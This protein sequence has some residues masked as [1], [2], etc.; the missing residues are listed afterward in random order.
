MDQALVT[1]LS[2]SANHALVTLVQDAI[3]STALV[4]VGEAGRRTVD[5]KRW[6]RATIAADVVA[7]GAGI[8]IQRALRARNREPLRA[9]RARTGG[10]MLAVTGTAG[11]CVG[12]LQ[13]AFPGNGSRWRQ[14][15][16]VVGPAGAGLAA[17]NTWQVR[18]RAQL[19]RG[20]PREGSQASLA[21]SIAYGVGM[22]A[23]LS[24]FG[25]GERQ[26][27]DRISS[28]VARVLPGNA[29][30]WRPVA[31]RGRVRGTHGRRP[32]SCCEGAGED[33]ARP[34]SPPKRRST[35]RRRTRW[36][37]EASRVSFRSTRFRERAGGSCGWR[38]PP[39]RSAK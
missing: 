12:A 3:Q 16:A 37:A 7:I 23:A 30:L 35:S 21:K 6:S 33:R 36:S 17:F 39:T 5:E 34:R 26:F 15:L 22:A 32:G 8:A 25:D 20:L 11:A 9:R 2:A 24:A 28:L 29:A 10:Y 1:G 19:D 27:A 14:T 4:L 13:E 38:F 31:R 18:K